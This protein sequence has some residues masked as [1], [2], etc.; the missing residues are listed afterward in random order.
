[1]KTRK[2]QTSGVIRLRKKMQLEAFALLLIIQIS[3]VGSHFYQ[4]SKEMNWSVS[5]VSAKEV[6]KLSMRDYVLNEVEK[7]GL[8]KFRAYALIA[9]E[10]SWNPEAKL[11]NKGG[12]LGTDR[13]LWMISDK[14]HPEVSNS[15]A[16]SPECSTKAAIKILKKSGWK[17]WVCG[18]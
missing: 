4:L 12:K 10:S 7:A 5:V 2:H 18:K 14:F 11:I 13:G 6:E 3:F 17:E 8:D 15:C 9:C 16:Y 1:M